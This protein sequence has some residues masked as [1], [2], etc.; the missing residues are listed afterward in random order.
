MYRCERCIVEVKR[1]FENAGVAPLIVHL[2]EGVVNKTVPP[3]AQ[4]KIIK[5]PEENG[6]SLVFSDDDKLVVNI[7]A[8]LVFYLREYFLKKE[9]LHKI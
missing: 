3:A 4:N 5:N 6:F 1:I 2:G 8:L 9:N 7:Q